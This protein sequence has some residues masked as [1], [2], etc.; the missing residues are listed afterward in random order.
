[1]FFTFEVANDEERSVL[2][3]SEGNREWE[4][5]PNCDQRD[6]DRYR[7]QEL[8]LNDRNMAGETAMWGPQS[9]TDR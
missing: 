6:Q 7:A 2:V 8:P 9:S 4:S 5:V 3:R 1:M